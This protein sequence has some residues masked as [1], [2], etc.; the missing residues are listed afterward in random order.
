MSEFDPTDFGRQS[1]AAAAREAAGKAETRLLSDDVKWLMSSP[2]GR[3]IVWRLLSM[4]GVFRSSF[5][6][7]SETFFREGR[8]DIGLRVLEWVSAH[9]PDRYQEMQQE[10]KAHD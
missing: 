4:A 8:R 3:R 5:T 10:S 1:D 2:R 7:N 6:G 9:A